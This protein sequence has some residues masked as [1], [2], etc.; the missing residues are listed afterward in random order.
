MPNARQ[1][2]ILEELQAIGAVWIHNG[3]MTRPHALLTSG[4]HSNGFVNTGLLTCRPDS[5]RRILTEPNGYSAGLSA[6]DGVDW[7]IGSALGA[8]TWAFALGGV[9]NARS[10]F[11]EK[12]GDAMAL[13]RFDLLKTDRVLVCEDVI[14]TG[15]S[16]LKTLAAVRATGATI[17]PLI[18]V[19]VNR[20]GLKELDGLPILSLLDLSID[21]WDPADCPL[22]KA[23]SAVVRPKSN[24]SALTGR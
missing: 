23:G 18:A 12:D 10:G 6:A 2:Q 8:V 22:C 4:R 13:K 3:D 9:L 16:T 7:V 5:I 14:S 15:G 21:S 24:W 11:T 19:L 20:S 17:L 1:Q